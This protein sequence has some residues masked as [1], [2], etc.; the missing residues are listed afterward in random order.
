MSTRNIKERM[1]KCSEVFTMIADL[2]SDKYET[3]ESCNKDFSKYLCPKGTI[4]EV[5]YESKPE[6]SFRISDHWNWYSNMKKCPD[7]D[8]IQ[9]YASNLP[10]PRPREGESATKPRSAISIGFY[11]NGQYKIIYGELYNKETDEWTWFENDILKIVGL[12]N[13]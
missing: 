2:L 7:P 1:K 10:E 11:V 9:C 4:G 5:T 8:Y 6:K 13:N 12:I 3:L